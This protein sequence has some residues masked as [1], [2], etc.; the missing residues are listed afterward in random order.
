MLSRRASESTA[1]GNEILIRCGSTITLGLNC[2]DAA[3]DISVNYAQIPRLT[4][5]EQ[6]LEVYEHAI[7]PD[8]PDPEVELP[9]EMVSMEE[10]KVR[11]WAS[12]CTMLRIVR[13][14]SKS[15]DGKPFLR[16]MLQ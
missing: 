8:Y 9:I 11:D 12:A 13:F 1:D 2:S 6:P 15:K 14:R 7:G 4:R 3:L 10:A 5:A 16:M